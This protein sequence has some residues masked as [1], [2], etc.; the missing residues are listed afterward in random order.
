MNILQAIILGLLQGLTEFIP[1]SSSGHLVLAH[2]ILGIHEMGLV[3]DVALHFGTM[4]ALVIYF[5]KDLSKFAASAFKK[6]NDSRLAWLLA[7]ATIPA[8]IFGYLLESAA[9]SQF[10]SARLVGFTMLVFGIIML[11]AEYYYRRREHHGSLED[12]TTKQGLSMGFAQALAIVPGVSRSGSTITMG[13]FMGLDRV[14]ATRFSFLLGIPIM[15]GAVLKVFSDGGV[16]QAA[17][18]QKT[19]FIT[20]VITA[21]LS[22]LFAI[23]FMLK[24]LSRHGLHVFA[25]YRIALGS[26]V[27]LIFSFS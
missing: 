22:G 7:A 12:I 6:N 8:A 20:G 13:L 11:V 19:I 2:H 24:F 5:Q 9:E 4:I 18:D 3:F 25:Y 15:A 21:L 26:L 16:L 14:S 1:I 27:L 17:A 10:R 23:R